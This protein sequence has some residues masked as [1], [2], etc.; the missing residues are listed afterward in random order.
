M[1]D[2]ARAESRRRPALWPGV[3]AVALA[4]CTLLAVILL[5]AA[6]K[7]LPVSTLT[8]DP[9]ETAG[10]RWQMGFLYKV[11]LLIWGATAMTCLLGAAIR[12]G[13]GDA[14]ALRAFLLGSATL[15]LVFAADDV[16]QLRVEYL[17]HLGLPEVTVF[18][19]YGVALCVFA[20]VF[21]RTVLRTEYGVLVAAL[22]LFV[23]WLGLRQVGAGLAAQD[24]VRLVGQ[25][26]LLLYF[27]RTSAYCT[28]PRGV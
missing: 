13:D 5:V 21:G 10:L 7:D 2:P 17:D 6:W 22:S 20:V 14:R 28:L 4:S 1:T 19:V 25:L 12:R 15:I 9:L 16:F 8:R 3:L 27:F 18:A 26:T 11:S 24:G 23:V